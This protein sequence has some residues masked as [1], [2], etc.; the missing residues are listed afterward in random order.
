[1]R[2]S[3]TSFSGESFAYCGMDEAPALP[4]RTR[5]GPTPPGE[6][7]R[8]FGE[9]PGLA[10]RALLPAD[11]GVKVENA[12]LRRPDL[13]S[14][15]VVEL[16]DALLP[17]R[18][19]LLPPSGSC[20]GTRTMVSRLWELREGLRL[21]EACWPHGSAADTEP[22]RDERRRVSVGL[23]PVSDGL[24]EGEDSMLAMSASCRTRHSAA[25]CRWKNMKTHG[26]TTAILSLVYTLD[27]AVQ[28][29]D[30]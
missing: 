8:N 14:L 16:I 21:T 26:S 7:G 24:W 22:R 4:R 27:V 15:E 6:D 3:S 13:P 19:C 1:M 29:Q 30:R 28:Y 2:A 12:K 17:L 5:P 18:W 20:W 9:D 11:T 10:G 25:G 23:V